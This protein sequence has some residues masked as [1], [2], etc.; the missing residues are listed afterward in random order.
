MVVKFKCW[1]G[2]DD[3]GAIILLGN[4][5]VG[6]SI[7]MSTLARPLSER[8]KVYWFLE[9]NL[10]GLFSDVSRNI[11]QCEFWDDVLAW[12][13]NPL[14]VS[15]NN[16]IRADE[17]LNNLRFDG[18]AYCLNCHSEEFR[19]QFIINWDTD[20]HRKW[21]EKKNVGMFMSELFKVEFPDLRLNLPRLGKEFYFDKIPSSKVL[22]FADSTRENSRLTNLD[23]IESMLG[24]G[25]DCV[26]IL[27]LSE[28]KQLYSAYRPK[29]VYELI[30]MAMLADY[31]ITSNSSVFHIGV[32]LGIPTV[33][34]R[35]EGDIFNL[36]DYNQSELR[37]LLNFKVVNNELEQIKEAFAEI[38]I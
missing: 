23:E 15:Y 19:G 11:V 17:K 35:G 34:I 3:Y 28:T 29:S 25:Y 36:W 16:D 1:R 6:D 32:A 26:Q 21:C 2:E 37:G 9:S 31:L 38:K 27:G 18:E 8:R 30:K 12:V 14:I 24:S 22:M 4:K 7:V 13:K 10:T 33:C 20:V 5:Y